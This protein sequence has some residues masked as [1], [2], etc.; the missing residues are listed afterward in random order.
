MI[1]NRITHPS[2][3]AAKGS[4]AGGMLVAQCMNMRPDLYRAVILNMPFLDV[5]GCLLDESLP[6][7]VTDWCEFGNPT[8]DEEAYKLISS[9]SPYENLSAQEYP[10]VLMKVQMQDPRVPSF[11]T[12]KYIEKFRERAIKPSK[13]P[14]FGQN[15]F[16]VRIKKEGGHFGSI[17]NDENLM[18]EVQEF[19]WLDFLML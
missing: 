13:Y 3:L 19:A 9:Y 8:E 14:D 4:S 1:A 18:E 6:L 10:A 15:N 12:L 2:L 16:V 7:S 11:S 5:L 17:N